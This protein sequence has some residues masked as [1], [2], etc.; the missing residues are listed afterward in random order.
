MPANES[1]VHSGS[2]SPSRFDHLERAFAE[3]VRQARAD[4]VA[5]GQVGP[6]AAGPEDHRGPVAR[7]RPVLIAGVPDRR[8]DDRQRQ[9]LERLDRAQGA[10]RHPERDRIER[11][12]VDEAAPSGIDLVARGPVRVEIVSRV[13]H[14]S[15][16]TSVIASTLLQMLA[17]RA[18]RSG[19]PGRMH[20]MPTMAT[21][22]GSGDG[23]RAGGGGSSASTRRVAP[24]EISPCS[25]A[26]VQVPDRIA[27]TCPIMNIPRD[28][29]S[30]SSRS[31]SLGASGSWPYRGWR[32]WPLEAIRSRPMFS[33]S[34]RCRS[35]SRGRPLRRS[36]R[37]SSANVSTNGEGA[38][39]VACPG[40]L[41]SRAVRSH[42]TAALWKPG[43]IAPA[44][45][46]SSVKR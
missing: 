31:S 45:T 46:A 44:R 5:T 6:A 27:A 38:H 41:S 8:A 28:H 26:I 33:S 14:R 37:F 13:S 11:D 35:S 18:L 19:A 39:R 32:S 30:P 16:G 10:G 3:Q 23:S 2:R 1:S 24:A 34:S 43:T 20:A 40:P 4:H 22:A 12:V 29:C 42:S 25:S 7:E 17:Q 36:R 21:A 9:K 15:A